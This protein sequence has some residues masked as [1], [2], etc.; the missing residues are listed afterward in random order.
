MNLVTGAAGHL[1]N[2]LV[3]ELLAR[4]EKV[5]VLILP[6]E[7]TQSLNGL[8][9][10]SVDGNVLNVDSLRAAMRD[11]DVVFH[12]AALVSITEE[13]SHLLQAVNVDGTRNVIEAAKDAKVG[14]LVYTSSIHALERPPMGVSITE[15]LAFDPN[16]PAGPYDRTK[17]QASILVQQAA[18]DGLNTSILCPTGVIGPYD[19]RRS[20]IGELI[21]SFMQKRI[22]FLVEGAFDFVDVRDVALGQ[23]LARDLGQPG[24][25]YILGGERIELKLFH[26]LVQ[27][28]TG[29]ET[30]VITFP[31]PVAMIVAPMAE[32]YYKLTKTRPRI[33][34]YA[35][36][37]VVSNSD[38]CSDKAKA[39]LGYQPRSLVS[40]VADTVRWWWDNLGLTKRS[41]RL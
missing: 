7:D 8:P 27:K 33:T 22:N 9:V 40:S 10:E 12:L 41:L 25:A 15:K 14:K 17:A 18:Q 36:E 26:D 24:E 29:K 38:I 39:E 5:R 4:G 21:L 28:V 1:G 3:R 11:V 34:R 16:N 32:L 2:V 20:E 13:K 19:Y 31:L 6:G 23:I 35:L 30:A 37:T